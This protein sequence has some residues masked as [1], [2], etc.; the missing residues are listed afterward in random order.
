M[1]MEYGK[2]VLAKQICMKENMSMIRNVDMESLLG[3]LVIFTKEIIS[4]I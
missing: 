3:S 4:K 2:E 1:V